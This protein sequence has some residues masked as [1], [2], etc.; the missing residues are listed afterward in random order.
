MKDRSIPLNCSSINFPFRNLIICA[1][2]AWLIG[3]GLDFYITLG[4]P[5]DDLANFGHDIM[6]VEFGRMDR[7]KFGADDLLR[8]NLILYL[9]TMCFCALMYIIALG[10]LFK[11]ICG[12]KKG[13]ILYIWSNSWSFKMRT[14][15]QNLLHGNPMTRKW[16]WDSLLF[17]SPTLFPS[18]SWYSSITYLLREL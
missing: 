16:G 15:F 12:R 11:G 7:T 9:S 8:A 14:C 3:W 1:V 18:L 5:S 13:T 17:V 4:I 6:N 2:S 10:T